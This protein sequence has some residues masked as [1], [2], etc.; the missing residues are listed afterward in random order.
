MGAT[1]C[2]GGE[3]TR[4]AAAA[5]PDAVSAEQADSVARARQDS[6][7]RAQP[8]YV[9]DSILPI[10]EQLRRFRADLPEVSEFAG[11]AASQDALVDSIIAGV[12]RTDTSALRR[13]TISRAEYA[14]L[15]YPSSPFASGAMQQAPQVSWFMETSDSDV[16]FARLITR[17][18]GTKLE[19]AGT[20][21]PASTSREGRNVIVSGCSVRVHQDGA[22]RD[23]RLFGPLVARD[24]V[25]KVLSWSNA[26]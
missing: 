18:G 23:L 7:N 4:A 19:R 10:E 25:W 24:G 16:G 12:A 2:A 6:I 20:R 1:A 17:L 9:V 15:I 13:L 26:F 21:C 22:T 11:G 3:G 14:W 8:G 5:E